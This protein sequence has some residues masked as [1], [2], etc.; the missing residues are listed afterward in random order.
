MP[1]GR[2]GVQDRVRLCLHRVS[3]SPHP[4]ALGP[5]AD[6]SISTDLA[7]CGACPG[8]AHGELAS[9]MAGHKLTADCAALPG[10]DEVRCEQ[11]R[12][13][14]GESAIQALGDIEAQPLT[15][16]SCQRGYSLE[17]APT[18]VGTDST[19][20]ASICKSKGSSPW[21]SFQRPGD[22]I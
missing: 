12:C 9:A 2:E 13:V 10:V 3:S 5:S 16:D 7:S 1:N 18:P 11:G 8:E 14:I 22:T 6:F 15:P 4:H 17:A 21:L 20:P 19:L